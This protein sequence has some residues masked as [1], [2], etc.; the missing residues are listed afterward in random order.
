MQFFQ[1][2][3]S[4][5]NSNIQI[6][7]PINPGFAQWG[8]SCEGTTNN[9]KCSS[10]FFTYQIPFGPSSGQAPGQLANSISPIIALSIRDGNNNVL[11]NVT[12]NVSNGSVGNGNGLQQVNFTYQVSGSPVPIPGW[13]QNGYILTIA[14][15]VVPTTLRLVNYSD[16]PLSIN[17]PTLVNS[18]NPVPIGQ[19]AVLENQNTYMG[20]VATNNNTIQIAGYCSST[21]SYAWNV[22]FPQ[23][24][25][26]A[27]ISPFNTPKP[28]NE[29]DYTP[30]GYYDSISN[31]YTIEVVKTASSWDTTTSKLKFNGNPIVIHGFAVS[32]LEY[33]LQGVGMD[34][35]A[36]YNWLTPDNIFNLNVAEIDAILAALTPQSPKVMPAVRLSLNAGYYLDVQTPKSQSLANRSKYPN[37][38]A[39]YQTLISEIVNYFNLN[40]V[41]C[42]LDLHWNDDVTQQQAMALKASASQI[43]GDSNAFWAEIAQKYANNPLVWFELYNEPYLDTSIDKD[44]E[45]TWLNGSS[46]YWGMAQLYQTIR[47]YANNIIIVGGATDYA[48]DA[49]SFNAFK[50]QV[51]PTGVIYN[52]HP[53]LGGAQD[54]EK[55]PENFLNDYIA[56]T[57]A[58]ETP[59]I[60]T[61][62]GQFCC[63]TNGPCGPPANPTAYPGIWNGNSMGYMEAIL[64]ICRQNDI[65]WT[66]WSWRPNTIGYCCSPDV[67]SADALITPIATGSTDCASPSASCTSGTCGANYSILIPEYY[68]YCTSPSTMCGST[69]CAKGLTCDNQSCS[70]TCGTAYCNQ[71]ETCVNNSCCLSESVCGSNCCTKGQACINGSCC[72][73]CGSDCCTSSQTCING[74]CCQTASVCGSSCCT[75]GQ[76]CVGGACCSNASTCGSSCCTSGQT[77][78]NGSCCSDASVCGSSCCASG[79]TCISGSCCQATSICGSSCCASG[80]TC[81]NGTCCQAASVCGSSC[82]ATGLTCVNGACCPTASVCGS[83]CCSSGQICS[84]GVCVNPKSQCGQY[85]CSSDESCCGNTSCCNLKTQTCCG[86]YCCYSNEPCCNGICCNPGQVCNIDD[87]C[88]AG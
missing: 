43:T 26:S 38:S 24:S 4:T 65:S 84:G 1:I 50:S 45:S 40:G 70:T 33:L 35:L 54:V 27:I 22:T 17:Y 62:G 36:T 61:E 66:L 63:P 79:Q 78:V 10:E 8:G 51:N 7:A 72:T 85:T 14:N 77:C 53:Y 68:P 75:S 23:T 39:Q 34:S 44:W 83:S 6:D 32:G 76:V 15:A 73:T 59:I 5:N 47:T 82:C 87:S 69:C 80:E 81:V 56:P 74:L 46:N 41:V 60:I 21:P 28:S 11:W 58:L 48:Y 19:L 57:L 29:I 88:V 42:I 2:T 13:D 25:G 64:Q 3:N 37:L 30:A 9:G 18:N 55:T 16:C 86:K 49:T 12:F 31:T 67:N 52:F 71:F 20:Q